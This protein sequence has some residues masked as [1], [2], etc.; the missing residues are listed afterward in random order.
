VPSFR[1]GTNVVIQDTAPPAGS[2]NATTNW[3]VVGI[4]EQGPVT[5]T[6]VGSLSDFQQMFGARV[7]YGTLS[8]AVEHYFRELGAVVLVSRVVGPA[9]KSS[10]L[11]LKDATAADTVNV[12]ALGPGATGDSIQVTVANGPTGGIIMTMTDGVT[13]EVTPEFHQ[14][15]EL[16]NWMIFSKLV[17]FEDQAGSTELPAAVAATPMTGGDDDRA[18]ITTADWEAALAKFDSS[19]GPGQ[20]SAPG[21]TADDIHLAVEDHCTTF[22]RSGVLDAPDTADVA[23]LMTMANAIRSE[24][25]H[26]AVF[27]PWI[28]LPGTSQGGQRVV[29]PCALIAGLIAR[30]DPIIGP[31]S[32]SA[33]GN[34]ISLY[35]SGVTQ[36]WSDADR[37][38]LNDAGINVVRAMFG[39][40]QV[41]VYGW[42]ALVDAQHPNWLSFG[43]VRLRMALANEGNNVLEGYMFDQLDGGGAL[44]N[45]LA[46]TLAG[47]L[48]PF[49]QSGQLFGRTAGEA[50]KINVGP[51]VNTPTTIANRELHAVISYRDSPFVEY[52]E[53]VL[54]KNPI[55]VAL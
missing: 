25:D 31:N 7:S 47:M 23:A 40:R 52:A 12:V 10:S 15:F 6:L 45:D 34:G 50:F 1:P 43:N 38:T 36:Q 30:N 48:I 22:E 3:F 29:P 55:S 5:P 51:Q 35:A 9:A 41:R 44:F 37:Q 13:L 26:A 32:P 21:M 24:G 33:G 14:K 39:G 54:V 49:W 8:D 20:V 2:T 28:V 16:Y 18:H 53:L 42:R 27:A 46:G 4:T 19:Y 11:M 17:S